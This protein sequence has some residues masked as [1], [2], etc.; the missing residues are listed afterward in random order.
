MDLDWDQDNETVKPEREVTNTHASNDS[1]SHRYSPE[2]RKG[3]YESTTATYM[4]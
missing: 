1:D 3:A 4:T 2:V